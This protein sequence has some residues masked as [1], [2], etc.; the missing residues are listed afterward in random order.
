MTN[1][2]EKGEPDARQSDEPGGLFRK[3]YRKLTDAELA[4]HDEIKGYA[5][6]MAQLIGSLNPV[7]Y[8]RV[9]GIDPPAPP[10]IGRSDQLE[11]TYDAAGVTLALRHLEDAVYRAVKALT[12]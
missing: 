10:I 7:A 6:A 8:Y 11:R 2:Y 12:A 1:I 5:E 9:S 4:I 3:R